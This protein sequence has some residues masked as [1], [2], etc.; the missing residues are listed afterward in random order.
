MTRLSD[1]FIESGEAGEAASP[2]R[3]SDPERVW[4]G[5]FDAVRAAGERAR[6]AEALRALLSF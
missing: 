1:C 3:F 6:L 2:L 5:G 4:L